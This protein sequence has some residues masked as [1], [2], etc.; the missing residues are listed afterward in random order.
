[1][2]RHFERK[3]CSSTVSSASSVRIS[4]GS[5][6]FGFRCCATCIIITS[7]PMFA[8]YRW[9]ELFCSENRESVF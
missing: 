6:N 4:H 5:E 1:M 7:M 3:E 9:N 8:T 2:N